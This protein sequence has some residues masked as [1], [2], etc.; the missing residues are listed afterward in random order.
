MPEEIT[1]TTH[2]Q[3]IVETPDGYR[4]AIYVPIEAYQADPKQALAKVEVDAAQRVAAWR[5]AVASKPVSDPAVEDDG[6]ALLEA[7]HD[8]LKEQLS[9]VEEQLA[10]VAR[11][12][13]LAEAAPGLEVLR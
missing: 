7:K 11:V 12:K 6:V 5:D 13:S 3:T 9:A 10:E 4:D 1:L 8:M 2:V